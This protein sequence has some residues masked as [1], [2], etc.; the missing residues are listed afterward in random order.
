[1]PHTEDFIWLNCPLSPWKSINYFHV[2]TEV[3]GAENTEMSGT[4]VSRVFD[5]PYKN[6]P[7]W[8]KEMDIYL[9]EM[10]YSSDRYFT[11]YTTCPKCAAKFG[12]NYIVLFALV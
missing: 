7:Y 5:G 6:V 8:K 2:T 10:G 12:H 9:N 11:F 3:P 4:F 1:M